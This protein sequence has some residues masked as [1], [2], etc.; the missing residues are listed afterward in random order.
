MAGASF[1]LTEKLAVTGAFLALVAMVVGT[2]DDP[3]MVVTGQ[4]TVKDLRLA[5]P[6]PQP[7]TAPQP[8]TPPLTL[9]SEA[10]PPPAP[11]SESTRSTSGQGSATPQPGHD[12]DK[13]FDP[14]LGRAPLDFSNGP[15]GS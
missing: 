7:E 3:G 12:G 1:S 9:A 2:E 14:E 15:P 6:D 4:E 8:P 11:P 5:A 10:L 13:Q